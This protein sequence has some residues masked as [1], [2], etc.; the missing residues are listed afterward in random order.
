M[1]GG[2]TF[3]GGVILSGVRIIVPVDLSTVEPGVTVPVSVQNGN[4]EIGTVY[5]DMVVGTVSKI[6]HGNLDTIGTVVDVQNILGTVLTE[7]VVQ[8]FSPFTTIGSVSVAGTAVPLFG[9]VTPATHFKI[10]NTGTVTITIGNATAQNYPIEP[11]EI[12]PWD[13]SDT[14]ETDLSTWYV[15]STG[16]IVTFAV[17]GL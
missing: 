5:T 6:L 10:R 9:V 12:Q 15:N 1:T 11:N 4:I 14:E 2:P 3:S 8:S 13:L 16:T 7:P 17:I